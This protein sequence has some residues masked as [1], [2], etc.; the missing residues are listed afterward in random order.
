MDVVKTLLKLNKTIV[1]MRTSGDPEFA[2]V[3]EAVNLI[4]EQY[5]DTKNLEKSRDFWKSQFDLLCNL[6]SK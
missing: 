2:T 4:T 1:R 5:D 6:K 3:V